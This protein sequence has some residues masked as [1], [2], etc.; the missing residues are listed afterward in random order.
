MLC[1][2]L[3]VTKSTEVLPDTNVKICMDLAGYFKVP[4]E[5]VSS[6]CIT[7]MDLKISI[8]GSNIVTAPTWK[9]R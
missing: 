1:W 4:C 3:Q 8:K 7:M 5:S 6:T 9:Q 2:S